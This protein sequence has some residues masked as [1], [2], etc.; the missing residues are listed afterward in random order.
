MD[1]C[2]M[3]KTAHLARL[4][5]NWEQLQSLALQEVIASSLAMLQND[6]YQ[7]LRGGC[8][9][10]NCLDGGAAEP[11]LLLCEVVCQ[12]IMGSLRA[13]KLISH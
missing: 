7:V 4:Q 12:T 10:Q 1:L 9:S 13:L 5:N 3:Q 6:R 11:A 2:D 8:A